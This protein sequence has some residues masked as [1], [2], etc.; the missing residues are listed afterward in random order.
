MGVVVVIIKMYV[1]RL[2]ATMAVLHSL[3]CCV[4][5]GLRC[6]EGGV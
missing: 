3:P 4:S 2:M 5:H 1:C 6:T